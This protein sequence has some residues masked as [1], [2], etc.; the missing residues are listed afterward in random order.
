MALAR[1][2][3]SE[4]EIIYDVSLVNNARLHRFVNAGG[5]EYSAIYQGQIEIWSCERA[6]EAQMI[7]D[8][9]T[10]EDKK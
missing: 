7:K 8:W 4:H 2:T 5:D 9:N 3:D 1:S 10:R 6:H